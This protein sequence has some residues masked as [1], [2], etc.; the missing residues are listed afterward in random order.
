MAGQEELDLIAGSPKAIDA[1]VAKGEDPNADLD[2]MDPDD[3]KTKSQIG[4][5]LKLAGASYTEIAQIAG[6]SSATKA[7]QA[8][9]R[10]LAAAADSPE[11]REKMRVLASRRINRLLQSVMG[12]AVDPKDP[13]HLAYNARALALIDRDAKLFGVDA[14][15]Q[16]QI[17][18]N[19][20]YIEE[21]IRKVSPL[22]AASMAA[23]EADILDAEEIDD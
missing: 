5:N 19:D 9:E 10:V 1:A 3:S 4:V 2:R 8:V 21:Y 13:Q 22:A 17:T 6:Y 16:I 15:T 12:K 20:A 11:D 7:R 14:P 18:P 23:D